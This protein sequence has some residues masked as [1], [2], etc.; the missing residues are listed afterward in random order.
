MELK[1]PCKNEF[2]CVRLAR[3][4]GFCSDRFGARNRHWLTSVTGHKLH[5]VK[6]CEP[7]LSDEVSKQAFV[8][9]GRSLPNTRRVAAAREVDEATAGIKR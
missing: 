6:L 4:A 1:N 2:D 5:R 8:G 9:G 3:Q 7:E